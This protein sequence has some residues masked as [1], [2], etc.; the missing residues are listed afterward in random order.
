MQRFFVKNILFTIAVNL[1]VKPVWVLVIDRSVQNTVAAASYGTY[2]ALFSLGIIFQTLLDF[3]ISNYNSKTIAANPERLP[4]LFPAM[5]SARLVL[6]CIYIAI[7]YT[8]GYILGYRGWELGL[9][10]GI[11]LIHSLNALLSFIRSNVSA[12]HRFKTDALLSIT[13]RTLMILICGFLLLYPPTAR[14]FRIQWFVIAQ[15]VCYFVAAGMGY[16]ILRRIGRVKLRFSFSMPEILSV[17]RSSFPYALLIFLMSVYNRADAVMIERL[18]ADGKAQA[19]IWAAAFRLL[20]MANILGLMFAT[21]LLPLFGRMLAQKDDVRP[22]VRLC[23]NMMLPF[24]VVVAVAA[25]FF[26]GDI[27]Y[28]LYH[29]GELYATQ[30]VSYHMVFSCL[31]LSFPAWCLMY[32]YSTLLTANGSMRA[33]NTIALCGVVFNLA[34]NYWL[35]PQYKAFGGAITSLATQ[36][37]LALAFMVVAIRIIKLPLN[38]R[39][40]LAHIGYALLVLALGYGLT[41]VWHAARP[42]QFAVFGGVCMALMFVFRFISIGDIKKLAN[43]QTASGDTTDVAAM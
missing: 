27:M 3:G 12:L 20:D 36:T 29:K 19:G 7:A 37:A 32:V 25:L 31:M 1:L 4:E 18:S 34:L 15:V 35:I 39:W 42:V 2:Q 10:A 24:S 13:D 14:A 21:M 9:L 6:M 28:L 43:R 33:L 5:L 38:L 11:L 41:V 17:M 8:W 26:G 22:I 30:H 16:V 23:V 40:T